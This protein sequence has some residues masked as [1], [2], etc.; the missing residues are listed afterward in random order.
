M[1][2]LRSK[3]APTAQA[4]GSRSSCGSAVHVACRTAGLFLSS[5][6][7]S[8]KYLIFIQADRVRYYRRKRKIRLFASVFSFGPETKIKKRA[9]PPLRK[10]PDS[11]SSSRTSSFLSEE[12]RTTPST[13]KESPPHQTKHLRPKK[14]SGEDTKDRTL[15]DDSHHDY[16]LSLKRPT[17]HSSSR[18]SSLGGCAPPQNPARCLS[19][20]KQDIT[21]YKK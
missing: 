12:K 3:A 9:G 17:L 5:P 19:H 14:I 8:A 13:E 6:G 1:P 21:A 18:N 7:N 11:L 16:S 4:D 20:Q 2:P 15:P 10:F